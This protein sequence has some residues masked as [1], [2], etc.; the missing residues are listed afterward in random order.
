MSD[1]NKL[2]QS[3]KEDFEFNGFRF[4]MKTIRSHSIKFIDSKK[5]KYKKTNINNNSNRSLDYQIDFYII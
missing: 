3:K 4:L 2:K 5:I 1:E